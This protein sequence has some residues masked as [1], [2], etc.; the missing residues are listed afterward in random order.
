MDN[1]SENLVQAMT[2]IWQGQKERARNILLTL[3]KANP[4]NEEAWLWLVE[5]FETDNERIRA[6]EQC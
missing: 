1:S 6:L 4:R 2:L 5:T 3:I